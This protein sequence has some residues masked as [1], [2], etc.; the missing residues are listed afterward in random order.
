MQHT[1]CVSGLA[2]GPCQIGR[3]EILGLL[4]KDGM[5]R[6]YRARDPQLA[7]IVARLWRPGSVGRMLK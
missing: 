5:G 3:D 4:G 6:V 7:R 1:T 2:E